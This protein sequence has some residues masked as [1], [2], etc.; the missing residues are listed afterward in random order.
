MQCIKCSGI[1]R[2]PNVRELPTLLTNRTDR[3]KP[4]RIRCAAGVCAIAP[5]GKTHGEVCGSG[6]MSEE[7]EKEQKHYKASVAEMEITPTTPEESVDEMGAQASSLLIKENESNGSGARNELDAAN[8]GG[9]PAVPASDESL[10]EPSV[11]D[12]LAAPDAGGT[13]AVPA[14]D[15]S[16]DEPSVCNG[17]AAPDAVGTPAVPASDISLD[18]PCIINGLAAPDAVGTPAVPGAAD[19][20]LAANAGPVPIEKKKAVLSTSLSQMS[21]AR[22]MGSADQNNEQLRA[23]RNAA[24]TFLA[25]LL[26]LNVNRSATISGVITFLGLVLISIALHVLVI[27]LIGVTNV[28]ERFDLPKW[29]EVAI[30]LIPPEPP[31]PPKDLIPPRPQQDQNTKALPPKSVESW[32]IPMRQAAGSR[33]A[34]IAG[35]NTQHPQLGTET[36][37]DAN[38]PAV[39]VG[40]SVGKPDQTASASGNSRG[41]NNGSGSGSLFD[42]DWN[43]GGGSKIGVSFGGSD[44]AAAE[45]ERTTGRLFPFD[46]HKSEP[47]MLRFYYQT[48][49]QPD[50]LPKG[51]IRQKLLDKWTEAK[52]LDNISALQEILEEGR[53]ADNE[54]YAALL[55]L[56]EFLSANDSHP[57]RKRFTDLAEKIYGRF[58][59]ESAAAQVILQEQDIDKVDTSGEMDRLKALPMLA[60]K[61]SVE[62]ALI[63]RC[64]A[65]AYVES[66]RFNDAKVEY[67]KC[68]SMLEHQKKNAKVKEEIAMTQISLAALEISYLGN[69]DRAESLLL[70]VRR[71]IDDSKAHPWMV[72]S[73]EM[74]QGE[75]QLKRGDW[76]QAQ[77]SFEEVKRLTEGQTGS[78]SIWFGLGR[79]ARE[80]LE[81]RLR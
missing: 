50:L 42:Q 40:T 55:H 79:G 41:K 71:Y 46:Y 8:A 72:P 66:K 22:P 80:R 45:T 21:V 73:V 33:I 35:Q 24:K 70:S 44:G 77:D 32:P 15:G 31:E 34:R 19:A 23:R 65:N 6:R 37:T 4:A 11:I 20:N 13:P 3:E 67:E 43:F 78:D 39:A 61:D 29:H 1:G 68:I 52:Y 53:Y 69:Y 58:S 59:F 48:F 56:N 9:T 64:F 7:K 57:Y 26:N 17:L 51:E 2:N 14:S 76:M 30:E 10:D 62:M 63:H 74:L 25:F 12:G 81:Q 60:G 36:A 28:H 5:R 75:L 49:F 18:D 54:T 27:D 47:L 38:A 16:L